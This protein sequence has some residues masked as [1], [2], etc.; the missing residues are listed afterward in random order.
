VTVLRSLDDLINEIQNANRRTRAKWAMRRAVRRVLD[1]PGR[2]RT[3]VYC[4]RQRVT[5]GWDDRS[6]WSLDTFIGKQLGEQLCYMADIAHG[7]PGDHYGTF[8]DWVNDLRRHGTALREYAARIDH[9]IGNTVL[10]ASAKTA[11]Y[12]V[13]DNFGALWD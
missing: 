7:W 4:A 6:V 2:L 8:E 5:R 13:G 10:Q 1:A 9:E 3:W 12:W 11:L